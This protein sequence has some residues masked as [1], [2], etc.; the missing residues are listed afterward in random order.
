MHRELF[1]LYLIRH[2]WKQSFLALLVVIIIKDSKF[3]L[4]RSLAVFLFSFSVN[5]T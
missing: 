1:E 4:S 2:L 3:Q 5:L